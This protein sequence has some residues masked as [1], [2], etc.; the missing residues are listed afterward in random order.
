MVKVVEREGMRLN[1]ERI[2]D[3]DWGSEFEERVGGEGGWGK[4]EM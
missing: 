4:W 1:I 2:F 3:E